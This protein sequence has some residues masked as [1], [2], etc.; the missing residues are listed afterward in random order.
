MLRKEKVSK[1]YFDLVVREYAKILPDEI[2]R[3][4]IQQLVGTN[5][6]TFMS[7]NSPFTLLRFKK[8]FKVEKIENVIWALE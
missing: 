8:F 1:R 4:S 6:Q 2:E 3:Q 5:A 7:L